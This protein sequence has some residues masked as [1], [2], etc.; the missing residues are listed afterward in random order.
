MGSFTITTWLGLYLQRDQRLF[1]L[2]HLG[3]LFARL[4]TNFHGGN[5]H[6]V[7]GFP[8]RLLQFGRRLVFFL[9]GC[10]RGFQLW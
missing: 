5:L 1:C 2:G 7:K 3:Q 6:F 8:Q 9:N 4:A 10:D